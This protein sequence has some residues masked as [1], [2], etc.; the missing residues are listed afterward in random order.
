MSQVTRRN[1][2]Y[3]TCVYAKLV[4]HKTS[5]VTCV[6]GSRHMSGRVVSH[7]TDGVGMLSKWIELT[8]H[9]TQM[10]GHVTYV[11]GSCHVKLMESGCWAQTDWLKES[12]YVYEWVI[13][14]VWMSHVTQTWWDRLVE[15]KM[16]WMSH[17]TYMS[18]V[19]CMS[20]VTYMT[21][22]RHVLNT[23]CHTELMGSGCWS[24]GSSKSRDVCDGIMSCTSMN[25]A[26]QNWWDRVVE[27][28]DWISQV[29]H[30]M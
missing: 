29:T 4:Q 24:Q 23:S 5:N 10:M 11:N 16:D 6:N 30:M 9:I 22:S 14:R 19:T 25:L 15:P 28:K 18:H 13:S 26:T 1:K 8:S 17:V 2:P 21:H 27:H 12:R 7:R 20:H 3:C